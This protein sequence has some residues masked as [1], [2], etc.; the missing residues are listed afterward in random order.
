MFVGFNE[1]GEEIAKITNDNIITEYNFFVNGDTGLNGDL[2]GENVF[3]GARRDNA[4]S[5]VDKTYLSFDSSIAAEAENFINNDCRLFVNDG[6]FLNGTTAAL[7]TIILGE[8][9]VAQ[10]AQYL[11]NVQ[12][13]SEVELYST[14]S[15]TDDATFNRSIFTEQN[16]TVGHLGYFGTGLYIGVLDPESLHTENIKDFTFGED[17]IAT[18]EEIVE[19]IHN[20]NFISKELSYFHYGL[21]SKDP[22]IGLDI[23]Y[24]ADEILVSKGASIG[25]ILYVEGEA[26]IYGKT[27]LDNQLTKNANGELDKTLEVYGESLFENLTV[28]S[29]ATFNSDIAV[30]SNLNVG[31]LGIFNSGVYITETDPSEFNATNF[32]DIVFFGNI[33]MSQSDLKE[34]F[35]NSD[36]IVY[37]KNTYLGGTTLCKDIFIGLDSAF[38][39]SGVS[40]SSGAQIDEI[41][42]VTGDTEVYGKTILNNTIAKDQGKIDKTLEVIGTSWFNGDMSVVGDATFNKNVAIERSLSANVITINGVDE[43]DFGAGHLMFSRVDGPNYINLNLPESS[44]HGTNFVFSLTVDN[45]DESYQY[46][47]LVINTH[48]LLPGQI[49]TG[50][51]YDEAAMTYTLGS[52]ECPW[53]ALYTDYIDGYQFLFGYPDFD[54]GQTR[55][56]YIEYGGAEVLT[57]ENITT[58]ISYGDIYLYGAINSSIEINVWKESDPQSHCGISIYEGD[59]SSSFAYNGLQI[60]GSNGKF[61]CSDGYIKLQDQGNNDIFLASEDKVLIRPQLVLQDKIIFDEEGN[62]DQCYGTDFPEEPVKGQI[63]FRII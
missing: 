27:T 33:I 29:A 62:Y 31:N 20:S 22:I 8:L 18:K 56:A 46:V 41:L 39:A 11:S 60:E 3:I 44:E 43:P 26:D 19:I 52:F 4:F 28:S 2:I 32:D 5:K 63:F 37:N 15:V 53:S 42:Y 40:I 12:F 35:N 45:D 47:P 6:A 50:E 24:F 9:L 49:L 59:Y 25:E 34:F 61:S 36:L 30:E 17:M 10:G 1:N 14:L 13:N 48:Q 58:S 21:L 54:N 7:D 23:A 51:R 57:M 38:F 16:L 55:E